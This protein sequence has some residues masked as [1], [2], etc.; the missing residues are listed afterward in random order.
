[1][2]EVDTLIIGGGQAGL[3]MGQFL[4]RRRRSFVI[5]DA[6]PAVG[7]SWRTRW[8]SLRLITPC[9]YNDLP[10]MAF[11]GPAW[12]FPSKDEVADYLQ[13][14]AARFELPVHSGC[15]VRGLGRAGGGFDVESDAGTWRAASVVVATGPYQ[16]P[17]IPALAEQ[18]PDRLVQLHSR[19]YRRPSQV[20][21]GRVLVVGC[22]N[23]GAGIAEDLARAG[24]GHEV[25]LAL[26]RTS[27]SP[28]RVL[29]RDFFWWARLF[30]VHRIPADSALG[31]R[32]QGQPDGLIGTSPE[33]LAREQGITLRP[34]LVARVGD[35]LRFADGSVERFDALVWATGF[36]PSYDWLRASSLE[37]LDERGAP[38]HRRGVSA[39]PGLFFLGLRWQSHIDSSLLGGVGRDAQQLDLAVEA[40]LSDRMADAA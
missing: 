28:R 21:S 18:L 39:V 32:M 3:A 5:L 17:R 22:G 6:S 19:D 37:L 16:R 40:H 4:R 33:Q 1:M 13:R 31:R 26:G 20:P 34:R 24:L 8:D 9:P 25:H 27:S 30:G 29:G 2:N 38:R 36:S 11:P 7:H 14:Y 12:S 23:S 10:G 15:R 35:E